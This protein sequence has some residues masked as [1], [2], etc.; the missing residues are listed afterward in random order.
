[1]VNVQSSIQHRLRTEIIGSLELREMRG[2]LVW[3]S[4]L[5]KLLRPVNGIIRSRLLIETQE[6][7]SAD[8]WRFMR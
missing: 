1:M 5:V 3:N 8:Q 2:R 4:C 6:Y 7:N